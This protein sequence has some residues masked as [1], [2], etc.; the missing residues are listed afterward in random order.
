MC[1]ISYQEAVEE[2][3]HK[4]AQDADDGVAQM[5]DKEHV[6]NDS[7]VA[8]GERPLVAHKTDEKDYLVEQLKEKKTGTIKKL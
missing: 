1:D 7:F 2:L 3:M 5:V 4:E 8:S 6:H